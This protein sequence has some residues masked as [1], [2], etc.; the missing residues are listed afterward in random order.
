MTPTHTD[1][2][3]AKKSGF[4]LHIQFAAKITLSQ[5]VRNYTFGELEIT[6]HYSIIQNI[7]KV[8]N[9]TSQKEK[10]FF[11]VWFPSPLVR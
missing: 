8:Y 9:D 1:Q 11:L 2:Q 3:T 10:L 7:E 6:T 5:R 4:N